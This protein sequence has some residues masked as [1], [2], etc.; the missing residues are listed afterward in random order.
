MGWI[1]QTRA[2]VCGAVDRVCGQIIGIDQRQQEECNLARRL[3]LLLSVWETKLHPETKYSSECAEQATE[4]VPEAKRS[5]NTVE[6][7]P[8]TSLSHLQS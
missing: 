4:A 8:K 7:A 5:E 6:A 1:Q 3:L 2:F